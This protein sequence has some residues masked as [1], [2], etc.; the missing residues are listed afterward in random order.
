MIGPLKSI[1]GSINAG[2]WYI[3]GNIVY[4]TEQ[5][6]TKI[7]LYYRVNMAVMILSI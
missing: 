3:Q 5:I 2:T 6:D 1:N 4:C 7:D